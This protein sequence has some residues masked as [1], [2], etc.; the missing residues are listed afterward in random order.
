MGNLKRKMCFLATTVLIGT[1]WSQAAESAVA[2]SA[3][4][5]QQETSLQEAQT[6]LSEVDSTKWQY[7]EEDDVYWQTGI[8]YC[9]APSD[10]QYETLSIYVPGA[11]M[12]GE[13]NGDGTYTCRFNTEAEVRGYTCETAPLVIPIETQN[14]DPVKAPEEYVAQA[15]A[16]TS[17]GFLFIEAGCRGKE[18][19]APAGVA[20]L[21]AAIRYLRYSSAEIPG[22]KDR[23]FVYGTGSGG[24]L[25]EVLAASGNSALYTPV[26][27]SDRCGRRCQRR[28]GRSL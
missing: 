7:Q 4:T 23:I 10:A 13:A 8:L 28:S 15:A 5:V 9:A 3:Q 6:A 22:N 26:S 17:S 12:D 24:A 2:E 16:Y 1:A 18:A 14:Y 21:K 11:Y 27:G 19:G 25:G 20:D